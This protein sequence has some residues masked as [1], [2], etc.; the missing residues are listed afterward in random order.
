MLCSNDLRTVKASLESLADACGEWDGEIVVVDNM[1][2]D[3]SW[4]VLRSFGPPVRPIQRGCSRGLGRQIAMQGSKGEYI[5]SMMDCD[6]IFSSRGVGALLR[7]YHE[8]YE[9]RMLMTKR[10]EESWYAQSDV[11]IA[12]RELLVRV[13]GW[14][15]I[16]WYEDWDLWARAAAAGAYSFVK[17]PSVN[18]PHASTTVR[19]ERSQD[20]MKKLGAN[21]AQ[22]V[23]SVRIGRGL[24]RK[25]ERITQSPTGLA[26]GYLQ[27]LARLWVFVRRLQLEP[28]S[29]PYFNEWASS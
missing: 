24:V 11:T 9:G 5:L 1:S 14:R 25:G 15:D 20:L 16:N 6:D 13:G 8:R 18:P 28:V 3:G 2:T 12:P 29:D 23:D 21:F 4:D 19:L 7:L 27:G 26:R 10:G 22:Y 17:Y